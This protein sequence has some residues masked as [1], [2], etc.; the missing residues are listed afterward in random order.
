MNSEIPTSE[1]LSDEDRAKFF[2]DKVI[3]KILNSKIEDS[4]LGRD[5][6]I[7]GKIT[8]KL[9]KFLDQ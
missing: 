7:I 2:Y 5:T 3:A 9:R 6:S 1:I 8:C 4:V